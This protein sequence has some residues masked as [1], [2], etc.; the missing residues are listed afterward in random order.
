MLK[1][2]AARAKCTACMWVCV[3]VSGPSVIASWLTTVWCLQFGYYFCSITCWPWLV[4]AEYSTEQSKLL[5]WVVSACRC[6]LYTRTSHWK[7]SKIIISFSGFFFLS[8]TVYSF[9]SLFPIVTK[10]KLSW[11]EAMQTD[12][13]ACQRF[14]SAS[15]LINSHFTNHYPY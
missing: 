14:F 4:N 8:L 3:C 11:Q 5:H 13:H 12:I 1:S 7:G 10:K 6:A 2:N 15:H 9:N